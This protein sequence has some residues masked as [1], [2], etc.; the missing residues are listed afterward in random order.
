MTRVRSKALCALAI[1]VL[2]SCSQTPRA[3]LPGQTAPPTQSP[4]PL[5]VA[6]VLVQPTPLPRTPPPSATPRRAFKIGEA[7]A[8]QDGWRLTVVKLE[9]QAADR[10]SR[11]TAGFRYVAV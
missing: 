9:E 6:P 4:P 7:I 10:F 2:V 3:N 8:F 1:V 11:L 5:T